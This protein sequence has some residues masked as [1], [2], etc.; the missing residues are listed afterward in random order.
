MY[1]YEKKRNLAF[2]TIATLFIIVVALVC[3]NQA[4][5]Q[6]PS[7]VDKT[8]IGVG[9][10]QLPGAATAW[11]ANAA[12]PFGNDELGGFAAGLMQSNGT[13]IRGRFH[14]EIGKTIGKIRVELYTD[15]TV[16]GYSFG[17]LGRDIQSGAN[18][19]VPVGNVEVKLG[20]AGKS[21]GAFAKP[22]AFDD[23]AAIAYDEN[24][25]EGFTHEDGSTLADTNPAPTGLS[26]QNRNSLV[27]RG[28]VELDLPAGISGQFVVMPELH[29]GSEDED[30]EPVDQLIATLNKNYAL[31][32]KI[33]IQAGADLAFQR[34]RDSGVVENAI[35]TRISAN[36]TF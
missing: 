36:L 9:L 12:V 18:G 8:S 7:S 16:K 28:A 31:S 1:Y 11:S 33:S 29:G 24:Y 20:L 21:G 5:A 22:N 10:N 23:L 3:I 30:S 27:L 4:N 13:V 6:L 26:F 17:E 19:V 35:A 25:L 34:F 32:D 15:G 2:I 14:A